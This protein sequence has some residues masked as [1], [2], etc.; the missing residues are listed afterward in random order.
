[1]AFMIK[2]SPNGVDQDVTGFFQLAHHE[3]GSL[4]FHLLVREA[5]KMSL[6]RIDIEPSLPCR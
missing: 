2:H 1:M 6:H 3:Q 5:V 4:G